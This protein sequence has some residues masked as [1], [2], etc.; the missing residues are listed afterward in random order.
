[1]RVSGSGIDRLLRCQYARDRLGGG[2][3]SAGP[4]SNLD[5]GSRHQEKRQFQGPPGDTVLLRVILLVSVD[6]EH[7]SVCGVAERVDC[8]P[9]QRSGVSLSSGC[10]GGT[11]G[12][13]CL[14]GDPHSRIRPRADRD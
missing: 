2:R 7:G 5:F 10:F 3:V 8:P 1:M 13:M 12:L 4:I 9:S 6:G 11:V 14:C